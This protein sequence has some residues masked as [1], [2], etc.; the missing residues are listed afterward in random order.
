MTH[1]EVA[2]P[3]SLDKMIVYIAIDSYMYPDQE[4]IYCLFKLNTDLF[5][6]LPLHPRV[7]H[8]N[9]PKQIDA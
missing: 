4:L 8:T 6:T 5:D 9:K 1:L 2:F 3:S 7:D